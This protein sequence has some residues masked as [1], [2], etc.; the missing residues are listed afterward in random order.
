M[1]TTATSPDNRTAARMEDMGD[2]TA[3][4]YVTIW[5]GR[6]RSVSRKSVAQAEDILRRVK[7]GRT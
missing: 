1:T 6:S 4:V 2:G 7:E 5:G 3:F